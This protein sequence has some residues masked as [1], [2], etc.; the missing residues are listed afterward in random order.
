MRTDLSVRWASVY[1]LGGLIL[2]VTELSAR[3][4]E[5][6]KLTAAVQPFVERHELAGA[7]MLVADKDKILTTETAGWADIEGKKPMQPDS[8][9]WIASQSKPITGVA[10]M[11]LVDDGKISLE[12]PVEKYLPEFQRQMYAAG[13]EGDQVILKKPRHP[14]TVRNVMNHTSG[15]PFKTALE[16]PT[17][18]LF[19]LSRRVQSYAKVPLDFDPDTKYQYSNAGINTGGRI[20]EV[21]TGKSFEAFLDE[22]L[23][24]PLGMKDTTFWPSAAQEARVAKSYKPGQDNKGLEATTIPQLYYPLSNRTQRYSMPA[25]GLF[26]TAHDLSRFYRMLLRGGELDGKR[27]LSEAA[28]KE[29]TKRQTPTDLK[30]SYSLGFS[31]SPTTFGHGGAFSTNSVADSDRGQVFIWLV[32][33]AGF[34]GEGGKSQGVFQQAAR[35]TFPAKGK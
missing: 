4:A 11:L 25:G 30:E 6:G 10:V 14:I 9:F 15:L 26:S 8:L 13:K 19:P 5:P 34:P 21:V 35:E 33:H 28:V 1:F 16:E 7:V 2:A 24:Q 18:D 20:I 12:D 31:V 17:L 22:R 27:I 29:L 23:C 32:Q 3:A